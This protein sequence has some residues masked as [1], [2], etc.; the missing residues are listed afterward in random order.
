MSRYC[1]LGLKMWLELDGGGG[2][3]VAEKTVYSGNYGIGRGIVDIQ[4]PVCLIFKTI[5]SGKY[6]RKFFHPFSDIYDSHVARGIIL[7]SS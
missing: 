7:W 5:P 4:Q 1:D 2:D 3:G 6:T